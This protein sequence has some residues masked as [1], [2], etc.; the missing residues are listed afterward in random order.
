MKK[1]LTS[2][3]PKTRLHNI[4]VPIIGLTGGIATGKS[5]VSDKLKALGHPVI[6]ADTLVK[7]I[8]KTSKTTDHLKKYYPQV[9]SGEK[10][11]FKKLREKFFLDKTIQEDILIT[12]DVLDALDNV[13]AEHLFSE[14]LSELGDKYVTN[15]S[16]K[17]ISAAFIP[18]SWIVILGLI[19]FSVVGYFLW[20]QFNSP[21]SE[22][23]EPE[24][25]FASY[26]EPYTANGITRN[27]DNIEE[28]YLNAIKAYDNG[29]YKEAIPSLVQRV[30]AKP[31]DF[32]TQ[33]LLGNSYLNVSPPQTQKA[34]ELFKKIAE[35]NSDLY[36]TTANWYLALA[37][38]QNNQSEAAKAIFEDLSQNASN[39]YANLSKQILSD[40]K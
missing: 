34:I 30:A 21:E 2:K 33:L 25:I 35:G 5:T 31:D 17:K 10:V 39:R 23:V 36:S 22:N 27:S 19:I 26:Y 8:Y 13:H 11:D 32:P 20:Q 12:E 6:C 18:V 15:Q 7:E 37:Y 40:W 24:E 14:Q 4:P 1:E 29:N 16:P 38:L 9:L 28:N 3:T